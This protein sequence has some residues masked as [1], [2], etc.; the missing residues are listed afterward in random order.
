MNPHDAYM[1]IAL[2]LAQRGL[3]NVAPNPAVGCVLVKDD[4]IIGRGWTAPGG[5]PHAETQAL[6]WA[7]E[8]TEGATVY[9]TLEPCSHQGKTPPCCDALIN[10]GIAKVVIACTDPNPVINGQGIA[11]LKAAGIEIIEGICREEA[12]QLNAGFFKIIEQGLPW[13]TLKLALTKDG[14]LTM[15]PDQS[16]WFTGDLARD[17][18]HRLRAQHDAIMVGSGTIVSD[19]P[20]LTCRL[21]GWNNDLMPRRFVLDR[22]N[23]VTKNTACQPC[24][25]L[26]KAM[27]TENFQQL[28]D[29]GITR[30]M[31]EGGGQIAQ[32]CLTEHLVD[33][34]IIIRS[35]NI[36]GNPDEPSFY[37]KICGHFSGADPVMQRQLGHD[38]MTNY[39]LA[40]QEQN[41]IN[42]AI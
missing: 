42:K 26:N 25:V 13:I 29:Q 38:R 24:T 4:K 33:E 5:R 18:V 19:N 30:V 32:A 6:A 23:R 27:L 39:L 35:D 12:K 21:N 7:G 3:G 31:V 17:Y 1:K 15:P 28:A 10:A 11:R 9:I 20:K 34:L 2:H 36:S 37:D 8:G 14:K 22:S 41:R 40:A 16:A